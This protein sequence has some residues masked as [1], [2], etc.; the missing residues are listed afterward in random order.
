[1]SRRLKDETLCLIGGY[2]KESQLRHQSFT[3]PLYQTVTYPLPSG[4]KAHAFFDGNDPYTQFIYTRRHNPTTD[5]L[6][7]RLTLLE[8]ADGTLC[9]SSGMGAIHLVNTFFLDKSELECVWSNRIY[10]RSYEIFAR[11]LPA[12]GIRC[13][14]ITDPVNLDQWEAK[15]T[16]GVKL[17]FLESPTNP[18]LLVLDIRK[19]AEI[20]RARGIHLVVDNTL[21]SPVATKPIALG[22]DVSIEST[23]KYISGNGSL[24]GGSASMADRRWIEA[25][26]RSNNINYGASPAPFNSWLCLMG[27]ETLGL[28][29]AQ[30]TENALAVAKFLAGHP[31]VAQVNYPGLAE[32]PQHELARIQM[33]EIYG[34][35]MSFCLKDQSWDKVFAFLNALELVVLAVHESASRSIVTHPASTNFFNM[36]K[37][38]LQEAGV[39]PGLIRLSVGLEHIDDILT[40]LEEALAKA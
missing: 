20:C 27:L 15:L 1:M 2:E 32:H 18:G 35:L 13:H 9:S 30:H 11:A 40:D 23:S 24:L 22:A 4:E 31:K 21:A 39:P 10:S 34:G 5:F 17:A 28:R 8:E 36:S 7:K 6:E 26:R 16:K 37:E 33:N 19:I 29:M 38:E 12:Y 25:M 14:M 3:P